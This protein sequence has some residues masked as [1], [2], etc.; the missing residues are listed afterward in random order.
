MK[1]T[2][3]KK[4]KVLLLPEPRR[5]RRRNLFLPAL[6]TG[7]L[8]LA[9]LLPFT[10]FAPFVKNTLTGSSAVN[11]INTGS[12]TKPFPIG[13]NPK[14]KTVSESPQ[15]TTYID[16]SVASNHTGPSLATG[17]LTKL[18]AKLAQLDWYQNL[19]SPISRTL[20]IQ[21]GERSEEVV[22]HFAHILGWDTAEQD[23][24]RTRLQS[25]VPELPDGKLYPGKYTVAKNADPESVAVA[26]AEKFN[27]EVR[28]RYTDEIESVVPLRDTLIIASLLE[29][30]AYDFEDMRYISGII[31]NRLFIN[32]RLQI[33]A[34]MQ[35]ARSTQNKPTGAE[36]WWPV[37]TPADKSI[38]SPY[39]TYKNSGLPPGPIANP[40][41]DA[42]IAAL[43]PRETDCLFY[44]H[45]TV[46]KFYC[47]KTYEEHVTLLKQVYRT[48][49]EK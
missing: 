39:N 18:T 1:Q 38:D 20:V 13:V 31:W 45:D 26:V 32:M 33:D 5:L 46:G 41:I 27:A 11:E 48:E 22:A 47:T 16:T 12:S 35:Y 17:W 25:E 49:K 29:R 36:N 19:A 8:C 4:P 44:F 34:T 3:S 2:S 23:I 10:S 30:E 7:G 24:F 21:S 6:V 40:S 28:T 14:T 37:P 15:V 43:N 42:I 9:L